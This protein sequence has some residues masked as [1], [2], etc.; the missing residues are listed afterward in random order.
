MLKKNEHTQ[1]FILGMLLN[2]PKLKKSELK[3]ELDINTATFSRYIRTI[4]QDLEEL[5]PNKQVH[6]DPHADS[7]SMV[8]NQE[9]NPNLIIMKFMHHYLK[10]S[11]TYH[12][13]QLMLVKKKQP[14]HFLISELNISQSY[15]N[16][17]VK[18]INTFLEP[19]SLKLIQRHKDLYFDGPLTH[20]IYFEF[21]LRS[22]LIKFDPLPHGKQEL[23]SL[24]ELA[25][26]NDISNINQIHLERLN[27]LYSVFNKYASQL[28]MI[29]IPD[30]NSRVLL[31][32]LTT[33]YNYLDTSSQKFQHLFKGDSVT[34]TNLI[35]RSTSTQ[36]ETSA[37]RQKMG[38]L[39]LD[40]ENPITNDVR[41]ILALS[42][43]PIGDNFNPTEEQE[44]RLM[45]IFTLT[46]VY[47]RLFNFNFK[48]LFQFDFN[49]HLPNYYNKTPTYLRVSEFFDQVEQAPILSAETRQAI[50]TNKE[51]FI[52]TSYI[53]IR[54]TYK[55]TVTIGLDFLYQLSF[56][57]Y[58]K[59]RIQSVFNPSVVIF[60]DTQE[61]PD[62]II[63]DY[64][65]DTP[66]GT[67][68]FFYSDPNS[69]EEQTRLFATITKLIS[70]KLTQEETDI[71]DFE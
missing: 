45:F 65:A 10:G 41:Q 9:L 37:V 40:Y 32:M 69:N 67:R 25:H 53:A 50:A 44:V 36:L 27:N 59:T 4:N 16:K 21:L 48:K 34:F 6:I 47:L 14:T 7:L 5:F 35:M 56:E 57:H 58:I 13:L 33:H 31:E 26:D 49:D 60:S 52:N 20:I 1:V 28:T 30:E 15:F 54:S 29:N 51:L 11:S 42:K 19:T 43:T 39:L 64:I 55:S 23:P 68:L 70:D 61:H 2:Y 3:M 18:G 62:L 17:L 38:A 24:I 46:L 12:L 63:A 22:A 66:E 8:Y 71:Y